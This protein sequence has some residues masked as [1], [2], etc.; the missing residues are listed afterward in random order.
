MSRLA[1]VVAT[2]VAML[3][4]G[5]AAVSATAA[6]G[7]ERVCTVKVTRH[8]HVSRHRHAGGRLH[9][10][11][12]VHRH[13][14]R[15]CR[16][17]PVPAAQAPAVT[18]GVTVAPTSPAAAVE[19][20]V[21]AAGTAP[22]SAPATPAAPARLQVVLREFSLSLSRPAVASG[23]LIVSVLNLGEDPH[24]LAVRPAGAAGT[25][26]RSDLVDPEGGVGAATFTLPPGTWTLYCT[27]P[28]HEA[29]GMQAK[30]TAN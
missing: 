19:P 2:I 26:Q 25:S 7:T 23:T 22:A 6:P 9:R 8:V 13:R 5:F 20:S 14:R 24:D 10:H 16:T 1:L 15:V 28:G 27:L 4:A 30:L 29:A 11:R 18:P 17:V 21:P 12:R 3:V